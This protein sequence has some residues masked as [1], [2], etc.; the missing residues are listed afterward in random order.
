MAMCLPDSAA[1]A[2]SS[3]RD[4]HILRWTFRRDEDTV[5]S[6]L[7]LN[8]DDAA[9]ELRVN[10]AWTAAAASIEQFDDAMSAFHRHAAIERTLV[11]DGWLLEAF[12]AERGVRP[13]M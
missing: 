3:D 4:V 2:P 7:G 12:E 10:R 9:Y 1:A 5:V 11:E 6:E 13:G 8:S